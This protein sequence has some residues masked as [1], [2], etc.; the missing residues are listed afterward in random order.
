MK[1]RH[2]SDK[3]DIDNNV[4][5]RYYEVNNSKYVKINNQYPCSLY[6]EK[7]G[8]EIDLVIDKTHK[9]DL[10]I[11]LSYDGKKYYYLRVKNEDIDITRITLLCSS[12]NCEYG[13][14][15]YVKKY[16]GNISIE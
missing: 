2:A 4:K 14:S 15:W 7:I 16:N 5:F 9:G 11:K 1:L 10:L 13:S 6:C 3:I 8:K 12:F